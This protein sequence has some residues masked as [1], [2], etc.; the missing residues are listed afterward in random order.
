MEIEPDEIKDAP[1][2]PPYSFGT[3]GF[4][5]PGHH[6]QEAMG[7]PRSRPSRGDH[8]DDPH[9]S[10]PVD[11]RSGRIVEW[12]RVA[13]RRGLQTGASHRWEGLKRGDVLGLGEG[14]AAIRWLSTGLFQ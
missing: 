10:H 13:V 5:L 7:G 6:L 14:K 2:H 4:S 12:A 1:R 11:R 9:D 3:Y 8:P